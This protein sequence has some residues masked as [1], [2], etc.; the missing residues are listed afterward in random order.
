[1]N[2][3]IEDLEVKK[4]VIIWVVP[5]LEIRPQLQKQH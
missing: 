1:M 2:Q 3:G 4:I 5:V